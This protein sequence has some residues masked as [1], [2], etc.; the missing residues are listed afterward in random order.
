MSNMMKR[1]SFKVYGKRKESPVS[2]L[3]PWVLFCITESHL[4]LWIRTSGFL[5]PSSLGKRM[6][7]ELRFPG[8]FSEHL[9]LLYLSFVGVAKWA[10]WCLATCVRT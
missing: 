2:A 10:D 1:R 8:S 6:E 5:K 9:Q 3:R 4:L 7:K